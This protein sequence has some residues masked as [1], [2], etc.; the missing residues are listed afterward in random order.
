M[1]E[2]IVIGAALAHRVGYGGHA[3]ALLQYVLGFQRLGFEVT[4]VDRL[5]PEMIEAGGE[6]RALEY[7]RGLLAGEGIAYCVLGADGEAADGLSRKE[8]IERTSEARLLLNVM[9]FIRD[10]E[11]LA[12]ARRR[13]FLDIDP[14][15][16][17]V[18]HELGLADVFA[19]HDDFV[20]VGRNV[21]EAGC[22]VP[23][24]GLRWLTIPPPVVVERCAVDGSGDAF[25]TVGS[26]RGPYDRIEFEGRT[27][28]LRAHEFRRFAELPRRVDAEFRVALEIEVADA[29]D[30]ALLRC[31]GWQLVE[32]RAVAGAPG[33]YL[34]FIQGSLAEFTV[35]KGIYVELASGWLGDR[36]A[37]YLASGKPA[38]VQDTGLAARYPVGA[39]LLTFSSLDE[40]V[41]G[42]HRI[43]ADHEYH[44]RAARR[45]AEEELDA[46]RVL[47]RL[48]EELG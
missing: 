40:A 34:R 26:W 44:A 13:V 8:A 19:G 27:L 22:G 25:T 10:P 5:E 31:N 17:Q 15:F 41:E 33:S 29:A 21:G 35:A 45:L 14:G 7:L 1:S 48:V 32:P 24:C 46:R 47:G 12:A 4:V 11:L 16:G 18:W 2:S 20:T 28:G 9:G 39:G 6:E 30:T 38:L 3:W 43:Q 37:C 23:T 36:S 42:V